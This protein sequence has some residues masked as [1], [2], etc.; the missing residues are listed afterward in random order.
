MARLDG[1]GRH[2]GT[3]RRRTKHGVAPARR[4]ARWGLPVLGALLAV[5]TGLGVAAAMTLT[6]YSA[7]SAAQPPAVEQDLSATDGLTPEEFF[8]EDGAGE[9][10]SP[11]EDATSSDP[12]PPENASEETTIDAD[13]DT[14]AD[15]TDD[16]DDTATDED[17]ESTEQGSGDELTDAVVDLVNEQRSAAGCDALSVD[18]DLTAA[19]QDHSEDMAARDY[20]SHTSPDDVGPAQRAAGH[21]YDAFAAEN[22]AAGQG[23][24]QAVM[25]SWMDS[26][27]HRDNILNC[28]FV[29][30]G[31]GE[32]DSNWT[33]KFGWE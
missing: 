3:R 30:I 8:A 33:Q 9:S 23:S 21:G 16:S 18:T 6:S 27:D 19:A 14:D 20:M 10:S 12:S 32:Q 17:G 15:E 31:V 13:E 1:R 24:A 7:D 4:A 28:D 25:D 22:V 29:A 2:V 26:D 5:P 11:P